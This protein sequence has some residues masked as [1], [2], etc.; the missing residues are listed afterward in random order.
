MCRDSRDERSR[1]EGATRTLGPGARFELASRDPQPPSITR[2]AHPGR[3]PPNRGEEYSI[4]LDSRDGAGRAGVVSHTPHVGAQLAARRLM[5]SREPCPRAPRS[6]AFTGFEERRRSVSGGRDSS[7]FCWALRDG[8]STSDAMRSEEHTSELQSP[9]N[10]VCR[11][12]LE[13]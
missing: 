13:K 4:L 6:D 1:K 10:L 11:L 2:L 3:T 7:S 12:L 9:C 8:D 5:E